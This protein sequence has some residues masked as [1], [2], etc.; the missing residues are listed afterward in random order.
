MPVMTITNVHI[1]Q[2]VDSGVRNTRGLTYSQAT[3]NGMGMSPT[4]STFTLSMPHIIQHWQLHFPCKVIYTHSRASVRDTLPYLLLSVACSCGLPR[5][6]ILHKKMPSSRCHQA[7][8]R[9][10]NLQE[11][12]ITHT[13]QY[14][15]HTGPS[16]QFSYHRPVEL[17][18]YIN[19]S[20][21]RNTDNHN[22]ILISIHPITVLI[23]RNIVIYRNILTYFRGY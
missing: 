15:Q 16:S 18:Q 12:N 3:L 21:Y 14:R 22:I 23:Y 19:I 1:N 2:L 9:T 10:A 13:S 5:W 6:K 7:G 17:G 20:I 11:R 8:D 4:Q